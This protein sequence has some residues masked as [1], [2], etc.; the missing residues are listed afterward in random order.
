[1]KFQNTLDFARFLDKKDALKKFR[2]KFFIPRHKG[3]E[4]IYFCGNSLG[5]QPKSVR[6]SIEQELIDWEKLGVEGHFKAKNPWFSYHQLFS[7]K[8]SKLI[9]AKPS[10]A[11]VMNSLTG[12]LHL[13]LVSFYRPTK[14]KF[15][16]LVEGNI[17][18]SDYYALESQ[19]Q[20]HGFNPRNAIIELNPRKGEKTLRTEDVLSVIEKNKN[21]LALILIGAVNYYTG[22]FF[23]LE[24][25][26]KKGHSVGTIVGFD[27]AHAIGNVPMKMHNW[28]VDF[29]VW[30]S[31]KYLNSGPGAPGG[32]FIHEKYFHKKLN[33][34][35]G[36]WGYDEKTRF[37]MKKGF[38][39]MIGAGS[40]QLSNAPVLAMA[41]HKAALE[42]FNEAGIN[43]L[44]KKSEMLTGYLEFLINNLTAKTQRRREIEILTPKNPNERGCQ[45]SLVIKNNGKEVFDKITK[46]GVIADW[47]EPDVIRIAPVPLYNSFEDV[48]RFVEILKSNL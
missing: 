2:E 43:N 3:K 5:L 6:A 10:E 40:W 4:A 32:L 14:K 25:I 26:T 8:I 1:M 35:A 46:A 41:A 9:G 7:E 37:Q 19:I 39:P 34:F 21:E 48:F 47:R 15:K 17:F 18:P 31:Y 12:N 22:Q 29:A 33:R 38:R 36:W 20:F 28:R 24:K 11:V 27:L 13:L 23:D 44:R 30:C 42:I 45:L 16:V